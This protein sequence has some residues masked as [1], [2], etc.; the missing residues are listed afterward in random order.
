M[1]DIYEYQAHAS[2][3]IELAGTLVCGVEDAHK[4][5]K[6]RQWLAPLQ[7]SK[8]LFTVGITSE[9]AHFSV[10]I[11][12]SGMNSDSDINTNSS[13]AMSWDAEKMYSLGESLALRNSAGSQYFEPQSAGYRPWPPIR[14]GLPYEL[15]GSTIT[16]LLRDGIDLLNILDTEMLEGDAGGDPLPSRRVFCLGIDRS[17][18]GTRRMC[19]VHMTREMWEASDPTITRIELS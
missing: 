19:T 7:L 1:D 11:I 5:N 9:M 17:Q 4:P 8:K 14:I 6:C 18:G 16:W 13:E 15:R 12:A 2:L 3:D 10:G